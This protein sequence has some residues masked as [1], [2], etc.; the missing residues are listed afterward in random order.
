[1]PLEIQ[2][3]MHALATGKAPEPDGLPIEFYKTYISL[4]APHQQALCEEALRTACLPASMREALLSSIPKQGKDPTT[5]GTY[6]LL[7]LLNFNYKNIG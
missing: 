4:L 2:E 3:A 5:M 6:R 7:A 1:M